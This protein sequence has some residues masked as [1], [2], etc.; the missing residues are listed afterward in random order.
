MRKNWGVLQTLYLPVCV[1]VYKKLQANPKPLPSWT[2]PRGTQEHTAHLKHLHSSTPPSPLPRGHG[3]PSHAAPP[4][5]L[6]HQNP[7][8]PLAYW[9]R[10]PHPSIIRLQ[11]VGLG[12]MPRPQRLGGQRLTSSGGFLLHPCSAILERGHRK[13]SEPNC[14]GA[15]APS[16]PRS[17]WGGLS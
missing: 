15:R 12:E 6:Q 10:A 2:K 1:Y 5:F 13:T 11:P 3:D 16:G 7:T 14:W 4:S 17:A 9:A 8:G